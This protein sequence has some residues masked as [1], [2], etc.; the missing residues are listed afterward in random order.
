MC[1]RMPAA[2]DYLLL[3]IGEDSLIIVRGD[4]GEIRALMNICRHRGARVCEGG[5]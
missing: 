3:E 1:P 5:R 2:G 4:D